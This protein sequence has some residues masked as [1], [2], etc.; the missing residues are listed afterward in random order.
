[1][2]EKKSIRAE[3]AI[4]KPNGEIWIQIASNIPGADA[5][6]MVPVDDQQYEYY[7][8]RHS[9]TEPNKTN[10]IMQTCID[11]EWIDDETTEA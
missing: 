8:R 2:S 7:V 10:T 11:G 1:L 3:A 9:I 5:Y 6:F 4:M